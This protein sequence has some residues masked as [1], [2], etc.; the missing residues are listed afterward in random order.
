MN[1][2]GFNPQPPYNSNPAVKLLYTNHP[3]AEA[4]GVGIMEDLQLVTASLLQKGP[5]MLRGMEATFSGQGFRVPLDYFLLK[6]I[7]IAYLIPRHLSKVYWGGGVYAVYQPLVFFEIVYL[8]FFVM[9]N[10]RTGIHRRLVSSVYPPLF[11]A[12]H[13]CINLNV[14]SSLYARI[15]YNVNFPT[16]SYSGKSAYYSRHPKWSQ[17]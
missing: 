17:N 3:P 6:C 2:G 16:I 10:Q 7:D 1:G 12:I 14:Y 4:P 15:F 11:L 9:I 8:P 5:T 13:H